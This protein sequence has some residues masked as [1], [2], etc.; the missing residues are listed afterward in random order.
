MRPQSVKMVDANYISFSM[1]VR[2]SQSQI[3]TDPEV[4][5]SVVVQM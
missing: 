3:S 5:H 4:L 2:K 1:T